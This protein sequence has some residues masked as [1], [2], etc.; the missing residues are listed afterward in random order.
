MRRRLAIT[1]LFAATAL[2]GCG[3]SVPGL[4][5]GAGGV[6]GSN[7]GTSGAGAGT[8]RGSV[9]LHVVRKSG[10]GTV[11]DAVEDH[12]DVTFTLALKRDPAA[13]TE[14]YVDDGSKYAVKVY[15]TT[16]R[17][18]G[19]CVA[20]SETVAD[21]EY[22]F[23][24]HPT[25]SFDNSISAMVDRAA[26]TVTFSGNYSWLYVTTGNDCD[27]RP[28]LT[29]ENSAFLGCPFF[30][31]TAKLVE[32]TSTDSLDPGCVMPGGESYTG[33]LTLTK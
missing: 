20:K 24:D 32:G 18:L 25:T 4:G 29:G 15:T 21:K 5:P 30:G 16:S 9:T 8:I 31:L 17:Q 27:G 13:P 3:T 1:I 11:A 22:A 23:K 28:P 6:V 12:F 14:S 10:D 26:K 19:D 2:A 7:A 33:S